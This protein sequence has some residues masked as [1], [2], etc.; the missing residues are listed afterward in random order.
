MARLAR[1]PVS[2]PDD[3]RKFVPRRWIQEA[4]DDNDDHLAP[5]AARLSR[6]E[7][8]KDWFAVVVVAPARYRTALRLAVGDDDGDRYCDAEM[9]T[10][11]VN[12]LKLAA[13]ARGRSKEI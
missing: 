1:R 7:L 8:F 13:I 6:P 5:V 9:A 12:K 10:P 3:L 4:L 2:V 11:R